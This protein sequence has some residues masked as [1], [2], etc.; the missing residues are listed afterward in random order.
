[1]GDDAPEVRPVLAAEPLDEVVV[2]DVGAERVA[3]AADDD[4]ARVLVLLGAREAVG[5]G[6]QEPGARGRTRS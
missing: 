1:M 6:F 3:A 4:E 5:E 2:L